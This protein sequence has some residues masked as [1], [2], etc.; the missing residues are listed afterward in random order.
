MLRA[1]IADGTY[2]PDTR[3]PSLVQLTA[4][5]GVA[6]V[7]AQKALRHLREEGDTYTVQGLGSFVAPGHDKT[8]PPS[9]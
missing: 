3:V 9:P 2:P 4:E 1:R 8:P 6:S 7:T 5:F